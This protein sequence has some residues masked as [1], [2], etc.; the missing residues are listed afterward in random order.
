MM[1]KTRS[2]VAAQFAAA[3]LLCIGV[4][5][6]AASPA[7]ASSCSAHGCAGK[8]PGVEGCN[9]NMTIV[10]FNVYPPHQTSP[11][12]ATGRNVYSI[13]CKA[14]WAEAVGLTQYSIDHGYGVEVTALTLNDSLGHEEWMCFPGSDTINGSSCGWAG[15]GGYK[16]ATGWPAFT[17]MVDGT[18]LTTAEIFL[19][20]SQ[21]NIVG[22][23]SA[24]Q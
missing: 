24:D 18:N 16:G 4:S 20:D 3:V 11:L 19:V 17:D 15:S 7:N 10:N 23:G 21:N 1:L 22:F 2:T 9:T 14:N 13:P 12:L 8:D 6:F 5:L